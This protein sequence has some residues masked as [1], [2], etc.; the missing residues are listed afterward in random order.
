VRLAAITGMDKELA[1]FADT[2]PSHSARGSVGSSVGPAAR[3]NSRSQQLAR[4][5]QGHRSG[6]AWLWIVSLIAVLAAAALVVF[7]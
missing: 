1:E 7:R 2:A 5:T 3:Q 4:R 6:Y